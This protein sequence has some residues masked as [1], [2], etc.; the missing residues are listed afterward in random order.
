M[1]NANM[2]FGVALALISSL[3]PAHAQKSPDNNCQAEILKF[4]RIIDFIRNTQGEKAAA[5]VKEKMLPAKTESEILSKDGSCGLARHLREK[6][7]TS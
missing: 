4:E 1:K 3:L 6:K 7:L 2:I 5:K